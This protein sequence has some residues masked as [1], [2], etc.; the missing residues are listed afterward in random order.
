MAIGP[1]ARVVVQ[2]AIMGISIL[3]RA[4]PAAYGAALQNAKKGGVDAA[5]TSGGVF[6]KKRMN[7]DEALMVL[8]LETNDVTAEVVQKQFDK[9]FAANAV[10]K[11]G[12]FYLQSKIYRAKEQLDEFIQEKHREN[13]EGKKGMG[14]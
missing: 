12:S 1:I 9:Y 10:E 8:N 7:L 13:K 2:A 4:L 11:G 3:A 14:D 5:K 6:S